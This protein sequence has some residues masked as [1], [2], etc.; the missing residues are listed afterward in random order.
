MAT[1]PDEE[2]GDD[3]WRFSLSDIEQREHEES[4]AADAGDVASPTDDETENDPEDDGIDA[5]VAGTLEVDA[6]LEAGEVDLENALF[7]VVGVVLALVVVAGFLN[8]WP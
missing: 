8:L 1:D 2:E 3:E 5:G 4:D 6:E 7:V